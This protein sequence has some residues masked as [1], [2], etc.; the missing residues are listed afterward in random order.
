MTTSSLRRLLRDSTG[1]AAVV[2]A[3]SAP[4]FV[5]ALGLGAEVGLWYFGQRK[6]QNAADVA[7]YAAAVEQ[8]AR[9]SQ[10]RM[11]EAAGTAAAATGFQA[12]RGTMTMVT[13]PTAGRFAGDADAVE[14]RVQEAVPRLFT[15]IFSSDPL[16]LGGRAVARVSEGLPTCVLA[17]HPTA[18]RAIQIGG[19]TATTLGGCN[20]H[21][22]SLASDATYIHGNSMIATDCLSS[23]GGVAVENNATLRLT[24]CPAV[25]MN[26]GVVPD[27]YAHLQAPALPAEQRA[28]GSV[29]EPGHYRGHLNLQ[30]SVH[31]NPGVYV[32]DGDFRV[33]ANAQVTGTD[34]TLFLRGNNAIQINGGASVSL[35]APRTGPYAD[36]VIF[37]DPSASAGTRHTINGGAAV[38]LEG[39]V[40]IPRGDVT[41]NGNAGGSGACMP[42]VA[43]TVHITGNTRVD[44]NCT[45]RIVTPMQS[46]RI[47]RIVE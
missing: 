32:I 37:G 35:T 10:T 38:R 42:V 25:Y 4:V 3:L 45:G 15:A 6:L 24:N 9:R 8:R 22:N 39:V 40:Y 11:L 41:I 28:T 30:G 27:P 31:L 20:V 5:G 12:E 14:V 44:V 1:A 21:S 26:A 29:L 7:A 34:V 18:S 2:L 33:N 23:A 16:P 13:P 36:V 46:S 47:V 19:N 17:L 43:S